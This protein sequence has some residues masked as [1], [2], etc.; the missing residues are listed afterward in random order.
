L[1]DILKFNPYPETVKRYGPG[2]KSAKNER[3]APSIW[4]GLLPDK[5]EIGGPGSFD[6][7]DSV[8]AVADKLLDGAGDPVEQFRPVTDEDRQD[9]TDLLRRQ[10]AEVRELL[11]AIR[12][13]PVVAVRTDTLEA[14]RRLG[15][16]S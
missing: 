12:A 15:F 1:N 11:D 8:E 5:V 14:R 4:G 13:R 10:Y 7:C 2:M 6:D 9:L 3:P 16:R